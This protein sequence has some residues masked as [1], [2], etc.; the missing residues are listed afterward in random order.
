MIFYILALFSLILVFPIM[1]IL[2]LGLSYWGKF[3]IIGL[4]FVISLIGILAR[5]VFP[6][7]QSSLLML[8]FLIV[9]T[10]ALM[11]KWTEILF[12][13]T[14]ETVK[15][16]QSIEQLE[17]RTENKAE[18]ME[19]PTL[20]GLSTEED[21]F[22][23]NMN[24]DVE[25]DLFSKKEVIISSDEI[26]ESIIEND[27]EVDSELEKVELL[28]FELDL[29]HVSIQNPNQITEMAYIAE[30][31]SLIEDDPS[32]T[33]QTIEEVEDILTLGE[34]EVASYEEEH[35]SVKQWDETALNELEIVA[36]LEELVL[37][38][39]SFSMEKKD[40]VYQEEPEADE[41]IFH[42]NEMIDDLK[43]N[44]LEE[45]ST[46]Q[47]E[48]VKKVDLEEKEI[49]GLAHEIIQN[50]LSQLQLLKG[51]MNEEEFESLLLRCMNDSIP[52]N[53]YFTLATMLIDVYIHVQDHEKLRKFLQQLKVRFN[54]QPIILEQ[55][56]YLEETYL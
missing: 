11:K 16:N 14:G 44:A 24:G 18:V 43:L 27:I 28:D 13:S 53:E 45:V 19:E 23:E 22:V 48:S 47:I 20:Y 38:S 31:E 55:I 17:I 1:Y 49:T 10:Y 56:N 35:Q 15:Q 32:I 9:A 26:S 33:N 21:L 36:D 4:G 29:S 30:I 34:L 51:Y 50:T 54:H 5:N 7:W 6:L 41:L 12:L 46:N 8:L 52:P 39:K 3:I 25:D 42:H 40:I 37:D 2:P